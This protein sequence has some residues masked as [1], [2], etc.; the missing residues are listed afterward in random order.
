MVAR[1][2]RFGKSAGVAESGKELW[3]MDDI[4]EDLS[5]DRLMAEMMAVIE[6]PAIGMERDQILLCLVRAMVAVAI[7]TEM[8]PSEFKDFLRRFVDKT[9]ELWALPLETSAGHA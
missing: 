1:R 8:P 7:V 6:G 4:N 2:V 3:K 9:D 5:A